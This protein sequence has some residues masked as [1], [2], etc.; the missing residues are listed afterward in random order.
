MLLSGLASAGALIVLGLLFA[1]PQLGIVA[2]AAFF[3]LNPYVIRLPLPGL[4]FET[5]F[6]AIAMG[7]TLLCFGFRIPPRGWLCCSPTVPT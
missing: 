1:R 5:V 6:I 7:L 2:L 3:P 4:N